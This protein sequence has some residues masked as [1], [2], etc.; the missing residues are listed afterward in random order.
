[1]ETSAK[2]NLDRSTGGERVKNIIMYCI[3]AFMAILVIFCGITINSRNARE[4]EI[5][6]G[7]EEAMDATISS[8]FVEKSYQATDKAE[9]ISDLIQGIM[10]NINSNGAIT[11]NV[12]KADEAKGL[13][14]VE[15]VETYRHVN[16]NTGTVSCQR[17]ICFD[18]K[19][20]K[21]EQTYHVYLYLT[22]ADMQ[23]EDGNYSNC[24]KIYE[25]ADDSEL[26]VPV[27]PVLDGVESTG[28]KAT[29]GTILDFSRTATADISAYAFE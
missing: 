18:T 7:L 20:T 13:L 1:M 21:A 22:K 8:L 19:E 25:V 11:V 28:W 16:G 15:V 3:A 2:G 9:F 4:D 26:P 10:L 29:D 24:Y 12:L 6:Q 5:Q 17:T 14:S 23:A 27:N